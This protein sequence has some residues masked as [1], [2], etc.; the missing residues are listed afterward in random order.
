MKYQLPE[1]HS[2]SDEILKHLVFKEKEMY[3][4]SDVQYAALDA[5]VGRGD[6]ILVSS[7]TSTG[8]THIALWAIASSLEG[9]GSTVYLVT[10]RAL[11]KQK[12]E[13]FKT[14]LKPGFLGNDSSSLVIA[15]GDYVEDAD[16]NIPAEPLRSPLIV[17]T[18]EKYLAM[19]SASGIPA[20]M[21]TTTI[22]CDEIQLIGDKSRGQNV[23]VLLTLLRNAGW[24]QF[25]GL[26]AVLN[27]KDAAD[28]A[29]WLSVT[30]V[31]QHAREK[32]LKY[33][34]WTTGGMA[35]SSSDKPDAIQENIA[36]PSGVECNVLAIVNNL[37]KGKSP[38][39]PIIVFCMNKKSTYELADR[40]YEQYLNSSKAQ[41]SLA[42]DGLPVTSANTFLSK[43]LQQR[44][45]SHNSDLLDDE[46]HVVEM[47][48]LEKKIDVVFSTS[49]LAAG[50]N[51]PLGAAVFADW[52]RW[53]Q[54]TRS[55]IP[56]E[57]SEF[58]NMAGR[59]GRMGFEH[60]QGRV[61]FT[62]HNEHKAKTARRYLE[63]GELP[64]LEPRIA[65]ERFNQLVLQ[66]V[67]S[68]LCHSNTE[69][70]NLIC[71][72]FSALREEDRNAALFAR[73][74]TLLSEAI[75]ELVKEGLLIRTA[76]GKLSATPVGK[77][78]GHS[79]LLPETG[80]LLLN[81][82][83]DKSQKMI[84]CLPDKTTPGDI[85]RLA[86][87]LFSACFSSPEFRSQNGKV[88][89][90]GLPFPLEKG[91]LFD[92]D[93][94]KDDL[95]EPT[96]QADIAPINAAKLCIDWMDGVELYRLEKELPL[97][98]AGMLRDMYRNLVW[99]LQGLASII[100]SASDQRVPVSMRPEC[101][102]APNIEL[103]FLAK[104]PRII[105]RLS[106]RVSEGIPDNI[107]W[108]TSLNTPTATY[109]LTRN[110]ILSL[111]ANGISTP[112]QLMLGS[113][114]ADT[115][116]ANAFEKAKPSPQAKA[117]WARDACRN[118]KVDQRKRASEKHLKRA[119]HCANIEL[120][121]NFYS[122]IGTTFENTFEQ[123][124]ATLGI[125]Y[126]KLDDKTKTGAPDY[127]VKLQD[128]PS[129]VIELKSKEGNKL[130]DYN[131]AVEVLSASEVH[132]HKD[133]FCVTLCHPGVDP[134]VPLVITACN[135]LSVVESS[136]LGEALLRMCEGSLT[137]QQLWQWLAS[138]GQALAFDLPYKEYA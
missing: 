54:D 21:G 17:A 51:F 15:T 106:F 107:L 61:I 80:V 112:E 25:V 69:V 76:T 100:T 41:L 34:C 119:K 57:T 45:A 113:G 2:L 81:Y 135:R 35:V 65:K 19:L 53:N 120:I 1:N 136:D 10:H 31:I 128:S 16:G 134:S 138:P 133:K 131:R 96:W 46:R 132:G 125:A 97:L 27:G 50:V 85:H 30:L 5:G 95:V 93:I 4:L 52:E 75:D 108:M 116:R 118:W 103:S 82:V 88:F 22:V 92:P 20:S 14:L 98:S 8:K 123:I 44:I 60:E 43:I 58:H 74:P 89:T 71:N 84:S 122:T 126:D 130:V 18:Y 72:T 104:L 129:I 36:L 47:H 121:N 28:L 64:S 62:A 117:N 105:R 102:R 38:P 115:A 83:A 73:W 86:F 109:R 63:L 12:F 24:K 87:L 111:R 37:L 77:A 56:I 79:G 78:I 7:P 114:E 33:E 59:V 99:V 90:R 32:H 68:E 39:T 67:S 49:T 70:V 29:N 55:Y 66:I 11:A 6:S 94:Y 101:L 137:Q 42:F 3:A 127:L 9:G 110:E 40:F 23:E 13:D 91:H 26:S 48:L 124:L